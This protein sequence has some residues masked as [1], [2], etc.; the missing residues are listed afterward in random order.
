MRS[1]LKEIPILVANESST[2]K[3]FEIHRFCALY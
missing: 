1:L 2:F 3:H